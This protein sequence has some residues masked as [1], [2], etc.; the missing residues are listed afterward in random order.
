MM[1][2]YNIMSQ[3]HICDNTPTDII[4]KM[5]SL[6]IHKSEFITR[7]V[8]VTL[9]SVLSSD[10]WQS[11]T[12]ILSKK[13]DQK[14]IETVFSIAICRLIGDKWQSKTLFL[15]IFDLLLSIVLTF[16]IAVYPVWF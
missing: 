5:D 16:L 6:A 8:K 3:I 2:Y 12:L 13:V 7:I 11:Q 15:T 9:Q 4:L 14:L 10:M 1:S